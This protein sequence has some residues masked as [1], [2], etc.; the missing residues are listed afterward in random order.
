MKK[1][2]VLSRTNHQSPAP[3]NILGEVPADF[4]AR[5]G[6]LPA[7]F[8]MS[9]ASRISALFSA[10]RIATRNLPCRLAGASFPFRIHSMNVLFPIVLYTTTFLDDREVL[11]PVV[12]GIALLLALGKKGLVGQY[13]DHVGVHLPSK[14]MRVSALTEKDKQDLLFGLSLGVDTSLAVIILTPNAG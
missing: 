4:M 3:S 6:S 13:L 7:A 10:S 9:A 8:T 1:D 12:G 5:A 11:P 14:T 2:G